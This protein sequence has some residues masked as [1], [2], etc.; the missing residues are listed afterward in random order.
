MSLGSPME[1]IRV[2]SRRLGPTARPVDRVNPV[3]QC[4]PGTL[5]DTDH[6]QE[7]PSKNRMR[8]RSPTAT[9]EKRRLW[10]LVCIR[11]VLDGGFSLR[12]P[13]PLDHLALRSHLR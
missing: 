6:V 2:P 9:I 12:F 13:F 7:T 4:L 5:W 1:E 8:T 3:T 10:V 11:I